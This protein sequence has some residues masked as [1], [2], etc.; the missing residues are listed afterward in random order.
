MKE[1]ILIA[2]P[3]AIENDQDPL[4]IAQQVK[5]LC[6]EIGFEYVFKG[7]FKK[8]NRTKLD[9]FMG[10]GERE[11]LNVLKMVGESFGIYTI[12]DVHETSDVDKVS[13]HVSHI[14]IPA[15]LCRQTELLLKAGQSGKT[16]N[17]KKGQFLSPEAM[18]F[19]LEKVQSTGNSRVWLCERGTT[20]GY[21]DLVVDA[22]SINRLKKHGAPVIMDCTHATQKPNKSEGVTGGD[23]EMIESLAVFAM[24]TG[25]DGLFIETH[26]NPEKASSDSQSM[27]K[28]DRL[29]PFLLKAKRFFDLRQS[30]DQEKAAV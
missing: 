1:P 12:T 24:S 13:P 2:G 17:I 14:Q 30:T 6:D 11:A 7:S 5:K 29:E 10:I 23:P 20:F 3:C 27:L 18:Q 28:L 26:P 9:S 16:I 25:A 15:F 4:S 19:A 22:T 21:Q 8:A